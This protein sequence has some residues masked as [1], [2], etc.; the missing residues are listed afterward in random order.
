MQ[1]MTLGKYL[2]VVTIIWGCVLALTALAKNFVQLAIC[3]F[4]L[5]VF[6][7]GVFPACNIMISRLYRRSEQSTR[8]GII[9]IGSALG[10]STG[11]LVSYGIG[12]MDNVHG[13]RA[14]QW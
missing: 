7:A 2:S 10:I 14:W 6:E 12:H 9:S 11:G 8:I 1:R 13:I 4:L 5:G 3:R